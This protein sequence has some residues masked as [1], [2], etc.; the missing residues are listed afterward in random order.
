MS[1]AILLLYCC[2][3]HQ[4]A[5]HPWLTLGRVMSMAVAV[6]TGNCH[7]VSRLV[8]ALD[9]A[10]LSAF[11]ASIHFIRALYSKLRFSTITI[12]EDDMIEG[13]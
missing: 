9:A 13:S 12:A 2:I 4:T 6:E 7:Q 8:R 5:T 1:G 11:A 3:S 10:L